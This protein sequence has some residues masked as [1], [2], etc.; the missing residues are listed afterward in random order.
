MQTIETV[1][2]AAAEGLRAAGFPA[3]A[4]HSS[5]DLM[6]H[7]FALY[8]RGAWLATA[9]GRVSTIRDPRAP[10]LL[11]AHLL[12]R[13]PQRMVRQEESARIEDVGKDV[14]SMQKLA[15]L[16]DATATQ[17]GVDVSVRFILTPGRARALLAFVGTI[18]KFNAFD[19]AGAIAIGLVHGDEESA[20]FVLGDAL[21]ER[22]ELEFSLAVKKAYR[23]EEK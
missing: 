22:G 23:R 17:N 4:Y 12:G 3:S 8:K 13:L 11:I 20:A 15:A 10:E 6:G 2:A 21:E 5:I 14:R 1:A 16:V 18:K 7:R 19:D 9:S